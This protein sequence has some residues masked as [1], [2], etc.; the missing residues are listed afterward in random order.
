[1]P[2]TASDI[3][4]PRRRPRRIAAD[5][6]VIGIDTREQL[7]Y[8]FATVSSPILSFSTAP[9]TLET[10]DY[11][12]IGHEAEITIERKSL[13]DAYKSFGDDRERFE[14]EI[15]RMANYRFAAVVIEA[16][17]SVI[18]TAP[19]AFSQKMRP[20]TILASCIAWSQRYQVHFFA[21]P[22]RSF[23]EQLTY[24]LIE[25]WVRDRRG[26]AGKEA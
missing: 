12:A 9:A 5:P 23:A 6:F 7:P 24:R 21:V 13:A 1:M 3:I 11:T 20:K 4:A 17:W 22:G 18:F 10:G 26:A 16:E 19:P 25:R 2:R 14:A 15:V 8:D